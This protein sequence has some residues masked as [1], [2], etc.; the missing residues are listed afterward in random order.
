MVLQ[1]LSRTNN[2]FTFHQDN[3]NWGDFTLRK[4]LFD[5]EDH[6]PNNYLERIDP[7]YYFNL[8]DGMKEHLYDQNRDQ[9]EKTYHYDPKE[10]SDLVNYVHQLCVKMHLPMMK[11]TLFKTNQVGA[12]TVP[13]SEIDISQGALDQLN[14]AELHALVAHEIAHS[15]IHHNKLKTK[16][17]ETTADILGARLSSETGM[18][19]L[20]RYYVKNVSPKLKG[21]HDH[22]HYSDQK[23]ISE[24]STA[25]KNFK[26]IKALHDQIQKKQRHNQEMQKQQLETKL[27][28][29]KLQKI[30]HLKQQ[31]N[32]TTKHS[33]FNKNLH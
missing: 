11:L 26:R 27:H 29:L 3:I 9:E 7:D 20:M 6:D 19:S 4:N 10:H 30:K 17:A 24:I 2:W 16:N 13:E 28:K 25:F 5:P 23:R 18:L 15:V 32:Q 12:A 31:L 33:K 21:A 22:E 14:Q 1:E 8:P